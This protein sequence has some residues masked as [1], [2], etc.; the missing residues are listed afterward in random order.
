MNA[1]QKDPL[2]VRPRATAGEKWEQKKGLWRTQRYGREC[3]CVPHDTTLRA[4]LISEHHETPMAGH[5]GVKKTMERLREGFFW[6]GM[7]KEVEEFVRTCDAC[8]RAGDKLSDNINVHTIIARHP[9]EVVTIDFLCGFAP[10]KQTK[11]TSIVVITNKFTRQIHLRSC[12]LNPSAQETAQYF[13]EMVLSRY[14][15]PRLIISDRG[16]QFESALWDGVM[17]ALGTRAALAS[18]HHPQ[19][20]GATERA[21]RTL[22]Q[23]IRKFVRKNHSTWASMLP[24]FEFAYNSAT[25]STTG[26][27]P[28]VAELARM[29]LLPVTILLPSADNPPLPKTA[30]EYVQQLTQQLRNIRQEILASDE[31]VVDSRNL[32]PAGSDED[33]TLLPGDEVLVY[34]PYL[35]TNAEHRKHLMAWKGPF[36]VSKEIAQDVFEVLGM[37]PGIPTAYHRSK[38]KRYQRFDSQQTRLSP[39][40]SPLKFVDGQVEYEVEEI[41]DHREVR[42]K[43]Q[44]LLQWKNTPEASWEWENNLGGC[45][46]LLRT[47]LRHIGER[48]RVLPPELTSEVP[49]SSSGGSQGSPG[50]PGSLRSQGSPGSQGSPPQELPLQQPPSGQDPATTTSSAPRRSRRLRQQG[51]S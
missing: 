3:V 23:M 42:G 26:V 38:L 49:R 39:S 44:Y 6:D 20:N 31:R 14:G 50:S 36:F 18:T 12:P 34:A 29:P 10:A 30:R 40:P 1:A 24:L 15:L 32:I 11:H 8:Q 43:R 5:F 16:S 37:G 35:P 17:K 7:R 28:F 21:N 13:V 25:H 41:L 2:Y 46:E 4:K 27:V 51:T 22:I 45:M 48:G 33:W 9:W 19:T 47:Y